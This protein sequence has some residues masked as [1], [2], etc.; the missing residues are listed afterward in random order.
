MLYPCVSTV[1]SLVHTRGISG[2]TENIKKCNSIYHV[3]RE[4]P[5]LAK[6]KRMAYTA[7]RD[8]CY[9]RGCIFGPGGFS[10]RGSQRW[11]LHKNT[12]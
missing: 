5:Q 9:G 1:I 4:S 6:P 10:L 3:Q 7:F 11:E 12:A 2:T 8:S